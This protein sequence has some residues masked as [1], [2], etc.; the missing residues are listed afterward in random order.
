M[1]GTGFSIYVLINC[2]QHEDVH[3]SCKTL[4][5]TLVHFD[6]NYSV[7]EV[8]KASM[9]LNNIIYYGEKTMIYHWNQV[10]CYH[11]L[12]ALLLQ[13]FQNVSLKVYDVLR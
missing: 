2:I 1:H 5:Q 7:K 4:V 9:L 6:V 13:M 3:K 8:P 12:L 11:G 10:S